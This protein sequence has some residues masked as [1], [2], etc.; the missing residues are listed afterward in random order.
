MAAESARNLGS[1]QLRNRE[2]ALFGA[3]V[4]SEPGARSGA[5]VSVHRRRVVTRRSPPLERFLS[6]SIC[7][8]VLLGNEGVMRVMTMKRTLQCEAPPARG[9]GAV[10]AGGRSRAAL[11]SVVL[12]SVAITST[13]SG[14]DKLLG[15]NAA[16]CEQSVATVRQSIAF[17]DFDLARKWREYAWKV[18]D[19]HAM[20]ATL[21]R[22]IVDGEAALQ[23]E[24]EQAKQRAKTL[25]QARINAA[26]G[27][28]LKFDGLE[29]SQRDRQ[30][31]DAAR[32]SAKRQESGLEPAY[33]QKL[34]EYNDAQ[35]KKR[36]ASLGH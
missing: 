23:T 34:A 11:V 4:A 1:L 28:W 33:A 15:G 25:A 17:K 8:R 16:Q 26:Q 5:D 10:R 24:A 19:D 29:P 7:E 31:L 30:S 27:V 2:L 12:A 36:Q 18:C 9:D 20:F 13:L 3:A 6:A 35:Y 14:C 21:D 32:A 22:E